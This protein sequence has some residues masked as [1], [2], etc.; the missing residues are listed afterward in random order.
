MSS[1]LKKSECGF[2]DTDSVYK[3]YYECYGNPS[4]YPIFI[5]H[6]GPGYGM[7]LDVLSAFS[8]DWKIIFVD[9]RGC[10]KSIPIGETKDNNTS[11]LIEDVDRVAKFLGTEQFSIKGH[12][13]GSLLALL[14]AQKSPQRVRSL[15]L[16]GVFLGDDRGTLI[17]KQGG[18]QMFYPELFDKLQ[19]TLSSKNDNFY[20][21]CADKVLNGSFKERRSISRALVFLECFLE[22]N[23]KDIEAINEYCQSVD[24]ESIA[25]IET[26]YTINNF[27]INEDEVL[28]NL[29]LIRDIPISILHGRRDLIVPIQSAWKLHKMLPNSQLTIA[30]TGGHCETEGEMLEKL[31]KLIESHKKYWRCN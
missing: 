12:S 13:W 15:I 4:G 19:E 2:V 31:K 22:N 30:E 1:V 6:G 11:K 23:G 3:I 27:F 28:N 7:D 21:I 24:C 18:F 5:F 20:E 17:G 9:Q 25:K 16:T 10:G 8:E 29:K 14:Y 26:Y